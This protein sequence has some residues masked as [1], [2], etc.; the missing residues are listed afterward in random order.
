M[1]I[2]KKQKG[3]PNNVFTY[4]HIKKRKNTL[5]Q[6][7]NLRGVWFKFVGIECRIITVGSIRIFCDS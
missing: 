4:S 6:A 2:L 5:A 1:T 3:G 7:L